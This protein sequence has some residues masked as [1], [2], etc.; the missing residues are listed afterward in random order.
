MASR[1]FAS[2]V[3]GVL[4]SCFMDSPYGEER[5]VANTYFGGPEVGL[6]AAIRGDD[7]AAIAAALGAGANVNARGSRNITPLMVAVGGLKRQ[8]VTELLAKGANPNLK[9]DDGAS[10]VSL[11][12]ENYRDAPEIM[13]AVFTGGGDPNIRSPDDDPVIKRFVND[14]N[15][16]F[17]RHM[18]DLG[19]DLNIVTRGG[20]PIITV[21]GVVDDWDIVWCL[22]E[23]GAKYDYELTSRSPLSDSLASNMPSP[24]SP[25]F[26]YKQKVWQ[27]LKDHGIAV[28]L[29]RE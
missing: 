11:A 8:A 23:L 1:K 17:I 14:R 5:R 2:A 22:I 21:A 9:G 29:M 28:Q 20:D 6:E 10:A 15:C 12:V 7:R 13:F 24:D 27:F 4:L 3:L 26:P 19:A 16:E 18:K 25:I